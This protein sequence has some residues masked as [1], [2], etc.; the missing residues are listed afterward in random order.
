[1][2]AK[3]CSGLVFA[4]ALKQLGASVSLPKYKITFGTTLE[5]QY[6]LWYGDDMLVFSDNES[7]I[8]AKLFQV[9]GIEPEKAE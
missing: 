6:E 8:V 9:L 1:M 7:D 4:D 5:G 3:R 2:K